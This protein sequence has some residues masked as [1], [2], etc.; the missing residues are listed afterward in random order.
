MKL[1]A[2]KGLAVI[3]GLAF[4]AAAAAQT[5]PSKPVRFIVG[6]PPG[7]GSDISARVVASAMEKRLG[8]SIVV[9]NRPGAAGLI[10][11]QYASQ[12][13]ADAYTLYFGNVT[14]YTSVFVKSNSIDVAAALDPVAVLQVGGLFLVARSG[15]PFSTLGEM[16]AWSKANPGKLNFGT[17]GSSIDLV[18]TVLKNRTGAD[19]TSVQYKGD[20]PLVTALLA[21]NE[22]DFGASN[23]LAVTPH[24]QAGKMKPL[25]TT[26]TKRSSLLP[27]VPTAEEA[28]APGVVFEFHL[29]L[30][31]PKGAPRDAV[32]RLNTEAV[33]AVKTQEVI[34]AFRKFGADPVGSTPE[35]QMKVFEAEMAFWRTAAKL[36]NFQPQ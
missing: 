31:A 19:F 23:I 30:W 14:P 32:R 26:R 5:Y 24:I 8:Q 13:P 20:A 3:A 29:G 21:N 7:G 34:D 11:L 17:I 16:V 4:S 25:F 2:F 9:E 12:Q 36:A 6:F 33:A 27:N 18:M 28:G 15:A 1:K 35:E 10:G 22:V